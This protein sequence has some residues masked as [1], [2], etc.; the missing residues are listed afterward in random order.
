MSSEVD[1]CNLALAHLG[2]SATVASISPAEST[3]Q[4]AH[5]ARFY[6]I[7]RDRLLALHPWGFAT[8]RAALALLESEAATTP[9]SYTYAAPNQLLT[10]L[11]VLA[12][13]ATE[14]GESQPFERETKADGTE[15]VLTN[16]EDA[17]GRYTVLVT[18]T[19]KFS[20]LFVDCLAWLLASDLAGPIV[21]G[22]AGTAAAR[23]CYAIFRER[24]M[25]AA[26]IDSG[27]RR[28]LPSHSVGWLT[29]RA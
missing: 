12:D 8:R 19:T 26:R 20:P 21:K 15:V 22:D 24:F 1:I 25:H 27:N 17:V 11:A 2:D 16:Q 7:A 6:P 18:D 14:D 29:A 23:A 4:A 3:A 9:W 13:D 10:M 28:A 5:C